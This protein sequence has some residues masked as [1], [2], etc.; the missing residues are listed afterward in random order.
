MILLGQKNNLSVSKIS[1]AGVLLRDDENNRVPLTGTYDSESFHLNDKLDVFVYRDSDDK[2]VATTAEP[3]I[4]INSFAFLSVTAITPVG[5]FLDWGLEKDLLVPFREQ[6]V[7]M[8]EGRK[9]V[10]YLYLDENTQR[11]VGSNMINKF[12]DNEELTI[13]TGEEVDLLVFKQTDLGFKVIINSKHEGLLYHNEIFQSLQVGDAVR[14]FVKN[15]REDNKVDVVLQKPGFQ[16][17]DTNIERIL[18]YLKS[19][20]GFLNL[21]DDSNPEDIAYLLNM[22]KKTFKKSIG[23]LF[24]QRMVRLEEDGVHLVQ[25]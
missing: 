1:P 3:L 22:S 19:H 10:V 25:Q 8:T 18:D 12:L 16:N 24:K 13:E 23:I 11:L 7:E 14:G 17:I 15:I 4:R 2:I 20:E 21:T 5:A 9:Y 6:N